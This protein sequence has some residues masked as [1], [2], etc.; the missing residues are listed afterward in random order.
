VNSY[1]LQQQVF[2]MAGDGSRSRQFEEG[3][4]T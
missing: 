1:L 3:H 2:A 4:L